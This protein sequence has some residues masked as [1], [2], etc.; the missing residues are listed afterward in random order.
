MCSAENNGKFKHLFITYFDFSVLD[1]KHGNG[2]TKYSGIWWFAPLPFAYFSKPF[3]F[4]CLSEDQKLIFRRVELDCTEEKCRIM[5][6]IELPP[7]CQ[8]CGIR[9]NVYLHAPTGQGSAIYKFAPANNKS[10]I[11]LIPVFQCDENAFEDWFGD[12]LMVSE[13]INRY[14]SYSI[15]STKSQKKVEINQSESFNSFN[16]V[17]TVSTCFK[18]EF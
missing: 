13:I 14:K 11:V 16:H 17:G 7:G 5:E 4:I 12:F 3:D 1:F 10:E 2:Q 6:K 15:R 9:K 8:H 18:P